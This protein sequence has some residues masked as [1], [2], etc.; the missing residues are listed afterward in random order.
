VYTKRPHCVLYIAV[1]DAHS[2]GAGE[3]LRI[4][5]FFWCRWQRRR[6]KRRRR[7]RRRAANSLSKLLLQPMVLLLLP[8]FLEAA[9]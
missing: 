5:W 6:R 9:Y 2:P 8:Q 7:R 1:V 3:Q 4:G